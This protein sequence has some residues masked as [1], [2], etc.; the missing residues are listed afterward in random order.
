M[1]MLQYDDYASTYYESLTYDDSKI[2]D[3]YK[4]DTNK[5]DLVSYELVAIPGTAASTTDAQGNTVEPTEEESA[6][7][8]EKAEKAGGAKGSPDK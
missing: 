2:N 8:L 7:A 5:Y 6:A 3:A 1:R 4:A